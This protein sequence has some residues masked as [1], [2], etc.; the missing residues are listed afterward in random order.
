MCLRYDIPGPCIEVCVCVCV[1]VC[2]R[3][4]MGVCL[5]RYICAVSVLLLIILS[6]LALGCVLNMF[7]YSIDMLIL[8][9]ISRLINYNFMNILGY[10]I[11]IALATGIFDFFIMYRPDNHKG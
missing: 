7:Y 1:W 3:V 2:I 9:S 11:V 5:S 4:L 6:D 8:S 10:D